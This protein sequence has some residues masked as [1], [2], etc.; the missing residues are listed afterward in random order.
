MA[1]VSL[2]ERLGPPGSALPA[3]AL[4]VM[5]AALLGWRETR[6]AS[7]VVAEQRWTGRSRGGRLGHWFFRQ[8]VR[9]LGLGAAY[10]ALYPVVLYFLLAA[11]AARRASMAYLDRALGE[12]R[13]WSRWARS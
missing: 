6:R 9:W 4:T 11:P 1:A 7:A 8:A 3:S 10:A 2:G 12:A 5:L 13:G